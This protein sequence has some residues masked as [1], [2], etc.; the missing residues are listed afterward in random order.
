MQELIIDRRVWM[1]GCA[2][3][4]LLTRFPTRQQC[5]VG[6]YLTALGA[7]D[8]TLIGRSRVSEVWQDV[9]AAATWLLRDRSS[10]E[11]SDAQE[12]YSL[13]DKDCASESRRE[14][15]IAEVFERHGIRVVFNG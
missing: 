8:E 15:K 5:C 14:Q 13:N 9:P 1:R 3:T 12:L 4:T 7:E 2:F 11:S 6:I 10:L